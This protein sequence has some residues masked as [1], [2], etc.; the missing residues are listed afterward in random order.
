MT[1]R[2]AIVTG[3]TQGLGRAVSLALGRAGRAVTAIYHGD[4]AAAARVE[5]ELRALG[6]VGRALRHDLAGEARFPEEL[7]AGDENALLELVHCAAAPF[8]PAPFHVVS[9][10]DVEAQLAVAVKGAYLVARQLA[11]RMA[12][13]GGGAIVAVLSSAAH[14]EPPRG[15]AAYVVAKRALAGLMAALA[16]ELRPRGIRVFTV[17]PR[18][19]DTALTSRWDVRL[20]TA[21]RAA[22]TSEPSEVAERIRALLD[23]P[24]TP[25]AGEDYAC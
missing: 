9:W 21:A 10:P 16:V 23:D 18:Y 1:P 2:R 22:G 24:G 3:G 25:G 17:S 11:P 8:V 20:R 15:F 4:E 5:A 19:M 7:L 12:R 6:A 14:G 13:A